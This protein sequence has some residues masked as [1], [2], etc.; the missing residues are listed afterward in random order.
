MGRL[1]FS[2][3]HSNNQKRLGEINKKPYQY[4]RKQPS[5]LD[6]FTTA[7]AVTGFF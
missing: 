7:L 2:L 6:L 4:K 5:G 1:G 3:G